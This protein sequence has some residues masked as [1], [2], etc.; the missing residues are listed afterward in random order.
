[1]IAEIKKHVLNAFS[2]LQF[3]EETHCYTLNSRVLMPVT[4]LIKQFHPEFNTEEKAR[5]YAERHGLNYDDV[6]AS[7]NKSRDDA[8]DLGHKAH[9]FAQRY[10]DDKD[11]IPSDGFEEAII[12][13]WAALPVSFEPLQAEFMV[14][15]QKFGYAGTIDVMFYDFKRRGIIIADYKTYKDPYK[16]FRNQMMLDP[17]DDLLDTPL[18]HAQ[19][20][21]SCYQIPLEELGYTVL[22]RWVVWLKPDGTFQVF[23]CDDYTKKIRQRLN[24]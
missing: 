9:L 3:E 23:E 2:E 20:Q 7:W 5:E 12:K 15:S 13:F 4:T 22:E 11:I 14:F 18:N 1:M 19:T 16:N 24:Y 17:F 10:Y 8:C 21:L 6:I